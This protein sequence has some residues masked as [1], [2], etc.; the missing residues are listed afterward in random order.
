MTLKKIVL[1]YIFLL[2]ASPLT[3]AGQKYA[4]LLYSENANASMV[5]VKVIENGRH[6]TLAS[7]AVE[8]SKDKAFNG[9]AGNIAVTKKAHP[10]LEFPGM[11]EKL[12]ERMMAVQSRLK[13]EAALKAPDSEFSMVMAEQATKPFTA[14]TRACFLLRK[15]VNVKKKQ[16]ST[17]SASLRTTGSP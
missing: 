1:L 16:K 3:I 10:E 14:L 8:F 17:S 11:A 9:Y 7:V 15:P 12:T 2:L 4:Y 13:Q 6:Q 5:L